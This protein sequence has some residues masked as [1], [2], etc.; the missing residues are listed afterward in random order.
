MKVSLDS[1]IR[2]KISN[3]AGEAFLKASG[4]EYTNLYEQGDRIK[5]ALHWVEKQYE[6]YPYLSR[7]WY[8]ENSS[9]INIHFCRK[10]DSL[11]NLVEFLTLYGNEFDF[12]INGEKLT[13]CKVI[14][15]LSEARTEGVNAAE[16]YGY[17]VMFLRVD[18]PEVFEVESVEVNI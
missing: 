1:E 8:V 3:F 6:M 14:N 13:L 7:D 4:Y 17:K 16:K 9:E 2:R 18:I 15:D 12:L 10:Y 5:K 11:K